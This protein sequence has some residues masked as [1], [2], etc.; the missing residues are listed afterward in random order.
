[1]VHVPGVNTSTVPP[2]VTV[3]TLGVVDVYVTVK[4]ALDVADTAKLAAVESLSL[5][6]PKVTVC[7]PFERNDRV[8]V[9][10]VA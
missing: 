7:T 3:H 8:T 2:L 1:M 4:P 6:A 5:S 9:G 10:A